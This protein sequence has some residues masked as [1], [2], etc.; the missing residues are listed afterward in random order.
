MSN[1]SHNISILEQLVTSSMFQK[2][3]QMGLSS[4]KI[5]IINE[6]ILIFNNG[7]CISPVIRNTLL[8]G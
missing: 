2:V 7:I 4:N 1:D 5:E 6:T 8:N 3:F